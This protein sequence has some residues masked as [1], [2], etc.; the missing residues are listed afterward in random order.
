MSDAAATPMQPGPSAGPR[1]RKS[2]QKGK[3]KA[4][5]GANTKACSTC[6]SETRKVGSWIVC[7]KDPAHNFNLA[8]IVKC[9]SCGLSRGLVKYVGKLFCSGCGYTTIQKGGDNK[10]KI[11]KPKVEKT[12]G[13]KVAHQPQRIPD[14]SA[15]VQG[16]RTTLGDVETFYY[17]DVPLAEAK[18]CAQT[19]FRCTE[20]GT[21][22]IK[23]YPWKVV[24]VE[25][26]DSY[27]AEASGRMSECLRNTCGAES[28]H[29]VVAGGNR[30][31]KPKPK[32]T[33]KEFK[34][35]PAPKG[36]GV[37][38]V[39]ETAAQVDDL[40]ESQ[41]KLLFAEN[42][43]S[44]LIHHYIVEALK[45]ANT[46]FRNAEPA[47]LKKL[48]ATA[49]K[50]VAALQ[51]TM[52]QRLNVRWKGVVRSIPMRW[53]V[54]RKQVLNP[55]WSVTLALAAASKDPKL[56]DEAITLVQDAAYCSAILDNA[57][58]A[59]KTKGQRAP[60]VRVALSGFAKTLHDEIQEHVITPDLARVRQAR[61]MMGYPSLGAYLADYPATPPPSAPPSPKPQRISRTLAQVLSQGQEAE[62]DE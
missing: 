29:V 8:S 46:D 33:K 31:S 50:T 60:K 21:K 11:V 45:M 24:A 56:D 40:S 58:P 53:T 23:L 17:K 22:A 42:V 32:K 62:A 48:L 13:K 30:G 54:P 18:K 27:A 35:T 25:A 19:R 1:Q 7:V 38:T 36:K 9:G 52:P 55:L 61:E 28:K 10:P 5:A 34:T 37:V 57:V 3:P 44:L 59:K 4:P 16:N 26:D 41:V 51:K 20:C 39:G 14:N 43:D 12:K 6:A 15:N 49:K 47:Q 2:G